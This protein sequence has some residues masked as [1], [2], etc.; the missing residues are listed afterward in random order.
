MPDNPSTPFALPGQRLLALQGPD[1]VRFAHAQFMSDVAGLGD[2]EWQW[3][4]W[5]TPKGRVIALF[6]LLR[7]DPQRLWLLLPDADPEALAAQLRRFVFRSKVAIEARPELVVSG[8]FVASTRGRPETSRAWLGSTGGEVELDMSGDGGARTL[9]IAPAATAGD[10]PAIN[11]AS[12][13]AWRAFDLAHGLPRIDDGQADRWT[14]QQL[15]LGRLR[16]YSVKKGCYPGQEIVARTH[17]LG[18]A[19]RG[20]VLLEGDAPIAPGAD[21]HVGGASSGTV[22]GAEGALALA[23]LPLERD[24]VAAIEVNGAAVRER[25]LQGGLAR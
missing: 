14:P 8:A 9:S 22:V 17:F 23:V 11:D 12:Q 4:G 6:A 3:S 2:G 13:R 7:L 24:P 10:A 16:A 25:P 20:L 19:K 18:Q 21:V 1:A 5:L 15:S